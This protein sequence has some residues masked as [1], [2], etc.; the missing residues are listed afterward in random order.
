MPWMIIM[1]VAILAAIESF[2]QK[3]K[4]KQKPKTISKHTIKMQ[5]QGV[6]FQGILKCYGENSENS[7]VDGT[8][9]TNITGKHF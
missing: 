8:K 4:T 5:L 7:G 6:V 3:T 1:G 9:H 2:L